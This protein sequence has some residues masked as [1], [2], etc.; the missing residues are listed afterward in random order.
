[1]IIFNRVNFCYLEGSSNKIFEDLS[2]EIKE[3]SFCAILGRSGAGKSTILNLIV[4]IE[5]IHGN[6]RNSGEIILRDKIAD[7]NKIVIP[8]EKRNISMIFQTPSLFPHKNVKENILFGMEKVKLNR[9]DKEEKIE[10]FLKKVKMSEYINSFPHQLSVGQQQR[11]AFVRA[12]LSGSDILLLDEPF[13]GLDFESKF[14]LYNLLLEIK[15]FSK[16]TIILVTHDFEEAAFF[17]NQFLI[18]NNNN[19]CEYNSIEDIYS[20]PCS[21][22]TASLFPFTNILKARVLGKDNVQTIFGIT[23]RN[24][25]YCKNLFKDNNLN[26]SIRPEHIVIANEGLKAFIEEIKFFGSYYILVLSMKSNDQFIFMKI[27]LADKIKLREEIY[28]KLKGD[29]VV[30]SD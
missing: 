15:R 21:R 7:S 24:E 16:K 9:K 26:Y 19:V 30:F 5:T 2:F 23:K 4:G 29:I 3:H 11:I 1:M 12:I 18:I 17:S 20:N 6:S 14:L 25:T 8:S 13:S 10:D 22:Y 28:I 27:D